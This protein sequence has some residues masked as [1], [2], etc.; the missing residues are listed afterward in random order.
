MAILTKNLMK[1][2]D[3]LDNCA[4][5]IYFFDDDPDGLCSFL[6]FYRN[7]QEGRGVVVKSTPELSK[8]F[9]RSVE[10]YEPDK[11]FVLD[12]PRINQDF[13]DAINLPIVWLDHHQPQDVE[14]V[15]Y[16]NPRLKDDED[17]RPTSYW[18]YKVIKD[19]EEM[20]ISTVGCVSDWFVP[21]FIDEFKKKYPKLL[22]KVSKKPEEL[23]Y[24]SPLGKLCR[25]FSFVLK[26]ST[27][28]VLS[29]VK[30]L[31]RI[32]DPME[33]M[34]KT[35][36]QGKYL[37]KRFKKVNNE[38]EPLINSIGE[39][40][41]KG[42]IVMFTYTEKTMSFT[43]DLSNELLYKYPG[44]LIIIGREKSGEM[45]CSLRSSDLDIPPLIE[46]ALKDVE[47]YGGGHMHACGACIK[48]NDFDRFIEN[49]KSQL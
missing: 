11:I 6:L 10:S 8:M 46:S 23:L 32:K 44:K 40:N 45:K 33:I 5:P 19:E 16:F 28:D 1:I 36:S 34:E 47:G 20:W 2:K 13:I 31:T 26:G 24:N 18:A 39:D 38:Y 21:E 7:K 42:N 9:V 29:C 14:R 4:R 15:E 37:Y 3:H 27:K 43:S 48:L 30:V 49:L 12:K 22:P 25:I 41:V 35:T 17:N